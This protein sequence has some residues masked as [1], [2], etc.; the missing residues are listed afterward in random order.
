MT[1]NSFSIFAATWC[2]FHRPVALALAF[3]VGGMVGGCGGGNADTGGRD[4]TSSARTATNPAWPDAE[5]TQALLR[6][7]A[8]LNAA[9]LESA[10]VQ[11]GLAKEKAAGWSL[12]SSK[13]RGA[14]LERPRLAAP[15]S[16]VK[17]QT[18]ATL[19][20]VPVYRFFNTQTAAHFYTISET[21]RDTV[22][23][24]LP[25]FSYEGPAFSVS[26]SMQ[27]GL[28][29]V[30]RFFN[31][32]TGVHFYTISEDEKTHI[33]QTLPQFRFEGVA[34]YASKTA[35]AGWTELGRFYVPGKGFHF[36][37]A[38]SME[39]IN[40]SLFHGD[41]YDWEGFAYYVMGEDM[42]YSRYM[43]EQLNTARTMGGFGSLAH[44]YALADAAY[45]HGNYLL[46]NYNNGFFWDSEALSGIDPVS[47]YSVVHS[48]VIGKPGFTGVM[49][50]DR[51]T[52]AG[53]SGG[54]LG[55]DLEL[56]YIN[57][58]WTSYD[59]CVGGLINTVFHRDSLFDTNF[60]SFGGGV[61]FSYY[62]TS[63]V[64]VIEPATSFSGSVDLPNSW[65][66]I[67]PFPEQLGVPPSFSNEYPDP[68]PSSPIKGSPVSIYVKPGHQLVVT[69]FE[70]RDSNGVLVPT[71]ILT[72]SDFPDYLGS[73]V[74]HL[75]PFSA[76]KPG[77]RYT[78]RFVGSNSG[79]LL[80]KTWSYTTK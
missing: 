41:V 66:A 8:Q 14:G 48:E 21:E 71:K 3:A 64:C 7:G 54:S 56:G 49:P 79:A 75:V 36:Y 74:A 51:G 10:A 44:N 72:A 39:A 19:S 80:T 17:R 30:Y 78:A 62:G 5:E 20:G 27:T 63:F 29:P 9:E 4:S 46:Q 55:E 40:T 26:P 68:L 76:L 47:G 35:G 25:Q 11:A 24:T 15:A 50:T 70:I 1:M 33:Q 31:M 22:R 13:K 67:Y 32:Q 16:L 53:F 59:G 60:V 12:M 45:A 58:A 37:T 18:K 42:S 6:Q 23:N 73:N 2:R 34:Y 77:M 65:V 38:S 28:S 43:F 69:S 61:N 57:S 52:Y